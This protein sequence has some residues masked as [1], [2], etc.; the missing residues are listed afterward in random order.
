M[1]SVYKPE[2]RYALYGWQDTGLVAQLVYRHYTL[3]Q[4]WGARCILWYRLLSCS[5]DSVRQTCRI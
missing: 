3:L 2:L 4:D 1:T 5:E